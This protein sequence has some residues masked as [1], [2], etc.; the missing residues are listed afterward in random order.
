MS[1]NRMADRCGYGGQ[2]NA[3]FVTLVTRTKQFETYWCKFFAKF[4]KVCFN[5][6]FQI[7]MNGMC[8]LSA[9][10]WHT[11][12]PV[13]MGYHQRYRYQLWHLVSAIY[14]L[15]SHQ[16]RHIPI[17]PGL[18]YFVSTNFSR[19]RFCHSGSILDSTKFG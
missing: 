11:W 18:V 5:G 3:W 4:N 12:C 14:G 1:R 17:Q 9:I 10:K 2:Q 15:F 8:H 6:T 16:Y 7:A 19:I 13:S